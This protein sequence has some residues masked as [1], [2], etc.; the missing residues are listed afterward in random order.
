MTRAGGVSEYAREKGHETRGIEN[1]T[2]EPVRVLG[3][4]ESVNVGVD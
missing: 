4:A 2:D 1:R 3:C